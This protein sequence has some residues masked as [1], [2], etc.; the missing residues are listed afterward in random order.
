MKSVTFMMRRV[1]V[2]LAVLIS[3]V[4][5]G[6]D[7]V[8]NRSGGG[9]IGEDFDLSGATFTVGSSDNTEELILGHI[10]I[11]ALRAAGAE[12]QDQT[13]LAGTVVN[14][15]AL[16]SDQIDMTWQYTGGAWILHLGHTDPIADDQEQYQM[17]AEEDLN[18]NNIKWLTPAPFN[19]TYA[20]AV[21]SEAYEELG[22]EEISDFPSLIEENPAQASL[23]VGNEF[24]TRDDGLP[25]LEEH[26][27][28]EFPD[29]HIATMGEGIIYTEV[30][31][32]NTCNFGEVFATDG[33][34][35]ALDLEVI[36]DDEDFFPVY[37]PALT[38]RQ[39][40]FQEHPQLA[41]I[42]KPI[43]EQLDAGTI[44]D[45]NA[46]VDAED[47]FPEEVAAEWLRQE[48]FIG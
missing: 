15:E 12:V 36:E 43:A 41:D 40:V 19:N 14:R 1:I 9:S 26:Y 45:L 4:S 2:I 8:F 30:D 22:V 46:A 48:G 34:I 20:L 29:Q 13:G 47:R 39:E 3:T 38:V 32:G 7:E 44:R 18:K 35:E 10:T 11:K 37:N 33:R 21:R 24:S 27:D 23:C 28:F 42:F 6:G 5:C 25:G 16:T 31:E 17:V